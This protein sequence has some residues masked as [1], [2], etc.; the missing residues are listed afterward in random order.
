MTPSR[1]M[2]AIY[3][4]SM[5]G[6]EELIGSFVARAPLL[7][8]LTDDLRR[9]GGQHHLLI[10]QRGS[11]KTTF[12]LRL[13][14]AIEDDPKLATTAIALR[15]PEEQYNVGQVSD[16]WLNCLDALVDA[17]EQRGDAAG[18]AKLDA[19][20]SAL[21]PLEEDD[22]ARESLAALLGWAKKAK[23]LVVLLIDNF[24]IVLDRLAAAHWA[25]RETLSADNGL[26]LIGASST[27][28]QESFEYQSAFY[29]FFN[30]HELG[31]LSD[32]EARLVVLRLA[33]QANTPRVA[34]VLEREP[35]R[36]KALLLLSGG[37]PRTLALLHG[38]LAQE[39]S[40][41]AED[42]LEALLDQLTPYYKAQ[43]DDLPTQS[44]LVVDAVALHWHPITAAQCD[45]KVRLGINATSA[46]LNRLVKQGVLSKVAS[47]DSKLTFQVSERFFNIWYLMRASRRLR[48][49]LLWLVG[50]LQTFYGDAE[51]QPRAA[52]LL[53]TD[54]GR[55][56][57]RDPSRLLAFATAIADAPMR[58]RL[59][60]RAVELL[61]RQP[62]SVAAL[63]ELLDLEGEDQHL[64]PV[65]DRVK[66][67]QDV[68]SKFSALRLEGQS[69]KAREGLENLASS[70]F[71]SL[72]QKQ[73]LAGALASTEP[74]SFRIV[75]G[76]H[77]HDLGDRIFH[78][79]STGELPSFPDVRG[80]EELEALLESST[81]PMQRV[82]IMGWLLVFR[83][84][85]TFDD[86][87]I[88]Q[89]SK[90]ESGTAT[91]VLK[92]GHDLSRIPWRVT[93]DL[94]HRVVKHW[95]I[96]ADDRALMPSVWKPFVRAGRASEVA[97]ILQ[98]HGKHE[99]ALPLY[100]AL[101]AAGK[102]QRGKLTHLAP[103][104]RVPSEQVLSELLAADPGDEA[105]SPAQP[106]A[107]LPAAKKAKR[108]ARRRRA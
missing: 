11:G 88:E 97:D 101:R 30:V 22:R 42:D 62:R 40:A 70:P 94:L 76:E 34:Q 37:T 86:S 78:S 1:R 61:V 82:A 72:A 85:S 50:F 80:G 81:T 6:R 18:A 27:F 73:Q 87:M 59:E 79:I 20:I 91:M 16:F 67:L 48:R 38:I 14:C 58:R 74:A 102:G 33:E 35:G 7:H 106:P 65:I 55:E 25:V 104:V 17:L 53:D 93:E 92:I 8:L 19:K 100:E 13:A 107:P 71:Y 4:P 69:S 36:F 31:G 29:D 21:E 98:A 10:G 108:P 41:R 89:L 68:R 45:A 24:D 47:E 103:E 66:G 39:S 64:V 28:L 99:L 57:T 105:A 75:G 84:P 56:A 3:N 60:F 23:R 5:L 15:F 44:Q 90:E 2:T 12:L 54:E 26:V 51:I 46:Q 83:G 77:R 43:F 63:A 95:P 49:R 96:H 32:E 52:E 9:G